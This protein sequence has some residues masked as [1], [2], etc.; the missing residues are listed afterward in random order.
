MK[1]FNV[2]I[3]FLTAALLLL[4]ILTPAKESAALGSPRSI[5]CGAASVAHVTGVSTAEKE[6]LKTYQQMIFVADLIV[7][8][9]SVYRYGY[10]R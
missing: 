9:Y 5:E 3:P 1:A 2:K 4:L 8:V 7:V 6:T 10:N